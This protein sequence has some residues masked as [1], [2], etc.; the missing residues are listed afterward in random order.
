MEEQQKN[1][2]RVELAALS[3]HGNLAKTERKQLY[4]EHILIHKTDY[5]QF[6]KWVF[7][8]GG[9]SLFAFGMVFFFAFN[10]RDMPAIYKFSSVWIFLIGCIVPVFF[11]RIALLTKQLLV[12][13][14]CVLVGILFAVFG[15]VY[16]TGAFTY[17]YISLWL[18]LIAVFVVVMHFA[19]LWILFHTLAIIGLFD[20]FDSGFPVY[21]YL[22][23]VSGITVLWN[24]RKP[25]FM[26]PYWYII[27][28]LTPGMYFATVRTTTII[29]MSNVT[30]HFNWF[31]F[32][33]YLV[34][35]VGLF[36]LAIYKKWIIP[37]AHILLSLIIVMDTK[38]LGEY[39]DNFLIP[40]FISMF[41]LTGGVILLI[42]LRKKWK[43][44]QAN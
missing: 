14:V 30:H 32:G 27:T 26:F 28:L 43:N 37:V 16:Q 2:S 8:V 38:I 12:T 40:A 41:A 31:E 3:E 15:Q 39:T 19:P 5:L 34:V 42:F 20:C 29:G 23:S 7:L 9:I 1:L 35:I 10:W 11:K 4:Q 24:S 18:A 13:L 6:I 17:Q 33:T 44:E 25:K 22:I 21:V 36:I